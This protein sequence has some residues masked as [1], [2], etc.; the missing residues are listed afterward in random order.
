M[1]VA[2][3]LWGERHAAVVKTELST[4]KKRKAKA[5]RKENWLKMKGRW[6]A[7]G[8]AAWLRARWDDLWWTLEE[9]KR[10]RDEEK[11]YIYEQQAEAS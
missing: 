1:G 10:L 5:K 6:E 2:A 3:H 11:D 8:E 9:G 4:R 7:T